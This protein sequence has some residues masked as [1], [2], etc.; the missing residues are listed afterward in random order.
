MS[1]VPGMMAGPLA[2][3]GRSLGCCRNG[4]HR[5]FHHCQVTGSGLQ[6]PPRYVLSLQQ[7]VVYL[8]EVDVSE[9]TCTMCLDAIFVKGDVLRR[10]HSRHGMRTTSC[11]ILLCLAGEQHRG[12]AVAEAQG[13]TLEKCHYADS[14]GL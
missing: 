14:C 6:S 7:V 2:G 12:W 11:Y 10:S 8:G 3:A 9:P 4:Q 13:L 5:A 1:V